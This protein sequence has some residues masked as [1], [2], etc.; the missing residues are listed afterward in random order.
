MATRI[1]PW[2]VENASIKKHINGNIDITKSHLRFS[3]IMCYWKHFRCC[4]LL[5]RSTVLNYLTLPWEAAK[6]R[7]SLMEWGII[8]TL[9][10]AKTCNY[11]FFLCVTI[12][13]PRPTPVTS[14][15]SI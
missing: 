15:L 10:A 9:I 3:Y 2:F 5:P 6:G 14:L 8:Y 13:R 4:L 1:L 12:P 11:I 7:E